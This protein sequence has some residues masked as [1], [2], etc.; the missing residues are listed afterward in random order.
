ML[1]AADEPTASRRVYLPLALN[2]LK[3]G[4]NTFLPSVLRNAP[5]RSPFGVEIA[6]GRLDGFGTD[7]PQ[8]L[9]RA[10]EL[11]APWVRIGAIN[12]DR[13]QPTAGGAYDW[14]R[15]IRLE[16]AISALSA[17]GLRPMVYFHGAPDWA[18]GTENSCAP[19]LDQH[20]DEY[21]A[22]VRAVV[23]RYKGP[24]YNVH[25]W[26]LGNEPDVDPS[27]YPPDV[28]I[29][30]YGDIKD[31]TYYGG[32]RYGR[33]LAWAGPAVKAA[34]PT[35]TVMMG[36]LLL[37]GAEDDR[38]ARGYP[39]RFLDGVLKAGGAKYVDIIPYHL[40][41]VYH[42]QRP[43]DYSGLEGG[44][45]FWNA[46]GGQA[47]GKPTFLQEVMARHGVRKP[48]LLNETSFGCL[49]DWRP[50]ALEDPTFLQHQADYLPRMIVRSLSAGAIGTIWFELNGPGWRNGGLLNQEQNP[51]PQYTAYKTLVEQVHNAD[52]PP[53]RVVG[54]ST[55]YGGDIEAYRFNKGPHVVDVA[56][57]TD[58]VPDAAAVPAA[59]FKGAWRRDGIPL[60]VT[61]A[62]EYVVIAVGFSPVY[63]Q[64]LP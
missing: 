27:L 5:W 54:P 55:E 36:G 64:R 63:I 43:A 15:L 29:G 2:R 41:S 25:F 20:L 8:T 44:Y 58:F 19:I 23:N 21:A 6:S 30:C 35:A 11:G 40:Y 59:K 62:G 13:V 46:Y 26:E 61:V 7:S 57:S 28:A 17:A 24:P 4:F 47:L 33:M 48:L 1:L 3:G 37:R 38:L 60:P 18:T 52:L 42:L 14:S 56:W 50:C 45:A 31:T 9:I 34:D 16:R 10:R 53:K 12:W 49:P 32:E 39:E 51:R 22:F